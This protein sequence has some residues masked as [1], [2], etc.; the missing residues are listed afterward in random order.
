MHMWDMKW[1]LVL[2]ENHGRARGMNWGCNQAERIWETTEKVSVFWIF[3]Q[4]IPRHHFIC[5]PGFLELCPICHF[6]IKL[7][8][9]KLYG[10]FVFVEVAGH[11]LIFIICYWDNNII[12]KR[13]QPKNK[14][15]LNFFLRRHMSME[16]EMQ[17]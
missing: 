10:N 15:L 16:L 11:V 3:K 4:L 14:A 8:M 13:N 6:L 7:A 2:H 12:Q 17:V 9:K 1:V 5:F